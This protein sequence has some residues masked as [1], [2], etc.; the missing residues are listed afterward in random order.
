MKKVLLLIV[1]VGAA[2]GAYLAVDLVKFGNTATGS[3]SNEKVIEISSGMNM[4]KLAKLLKEQGLI[5]DEYK[6]RLYAK[7]LGRGKHIKK[8]E[9]KLD[10]GMTPQGMIDIVSSGKSIQYSITFPEGSNIY[11]MAE[12]L[13]QRG[14]IKGKSFL[15]TV[16]D[17]KLVQETLGRAAPSLEGY[18]FPETYDITHFTSAKELVKM[19]LAKFNEN[20]AALAKTAEVKMPK[21]ELVTLASVVEKETGAPEER[22][23]IASIFYNRLK[24]GIPLQSDPTILY[25]IIDATGKPT[26]N[27]TKADITRPN[28]YNTYTVKRLP[29]GPIANPG[30]EALAATMKPAQTNYLYFVSR[31]DG[32]HVF[33]ST[34][35]DHLKAVKKFQLDPHAREGHSWR[36]LKTR[37]TN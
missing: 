11:D 22:P 1:I 4:T 17:P 27:I 29:Y 32:T 36:E 34:Y 37:K 9:Y 23:L 10:G 13:D 8:G 35:A 25:G 24:K 26:N 14:L 16:R 12:L 6:M 7:I 15:D 18:L 20:Y 19:M 2:I 21:H 33:T 5:Q 30:R 31:N 28:R 3:S